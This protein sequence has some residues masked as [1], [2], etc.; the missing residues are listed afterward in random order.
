VIV[1]RPP[2]A[3]QILDDG[4]TISCETPRVNTERAFRPRLVVSGDR[5]SA[6]LDH[7]LS[8]SGAQTSRSVRN[9]AD[10]VATAGTRSAEKRVR[11]RSAR[12]WLGGT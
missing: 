8:N 4:L 2:G 5:D 10:L 6:E 3:C 11:T 7:A 12:E 1:S 9:P